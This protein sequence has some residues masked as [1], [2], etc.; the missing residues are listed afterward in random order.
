MGLWG[1]T[2]GF[3]AEKRT[4]LVPWQIG[5]GETGHG[6]GRVDVSGSGDEL[7]V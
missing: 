7:R 5:G 4:E 1:A 6:A 3:L 2:G